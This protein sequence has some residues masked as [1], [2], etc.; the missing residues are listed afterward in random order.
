MANLTFS[1]KQMIESVFRMSSGYF[2]DFSN[3]EF[4]EFMHD[5][6]PYSIN[7]KYP[8]LSK[9]KMF[10]NFLKNESEVYVGKALIM[11]INYMNEKNIVLMQDK[12]KAEKLYELGKKFLGKTT[13]QSVPKPNNPTAPKLS[14]DDYN[15]LN[16]AL[17]DLE[18]ITDSQKRGYSFEKYLNSLFKSFDLNPHASYR[19][20]FDQIDGSFVLGGDTILIEAKY[21]SHAIP[22]DDLILFSN[23]IV[24]KSHFVKGLFIT[25]SQVDNKAIEY[26]LDRG[27]RIVVLTVE[28][29]YLMCQN[30]IPLMTVLQ[31]KFRALD[32]TGLIFKHLL[33]LN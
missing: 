22:K 20:E 2:L 18:K 4:E 8:G 3:R 27:S 9:A 12:E 11:L 15:S 7:G 5:I 28:E 26:F 32:E 1:E 31:S 21:R 6:V 14:E 13:S 23:K 16:K 10:R 25:F 29:L 24:S 17:L 19:T 33:T 30:R